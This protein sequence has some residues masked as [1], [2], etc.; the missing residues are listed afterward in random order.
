MEKIEGV[1]LEQWMEFRNYQRLSEAQ[2]LSWLK[3]LVEIFADPIVKKYSH[4]LTEVEP[5]N[6]YTAYE[7][8]AQQANANYSKQNNLV[9]EVAKWINDTRLVSQSENL[10]KVISEIES[11]KI[12]LRDSKDRK[13]F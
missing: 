13:P 11:L 7:Y 5:K 9:V 3:Q 10:D 12:R 4:R 6:L 2:A 1:N 8:L